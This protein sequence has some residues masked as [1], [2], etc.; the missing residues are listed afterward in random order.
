MDT[1]AKMSELKTINSASH[2][3]DDIELA[4]SGCS[5]PVKTK[6]SLNVARAGTVTAM[7]IDLET[8]PVVAVA[9]MT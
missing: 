2:A 8:E 6:L 3:W 5:S 9:V 1:N 7:V 4:L